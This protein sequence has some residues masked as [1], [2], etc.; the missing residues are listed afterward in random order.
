MDHAGAVLGP[1]VAVAVLT[2]W[3]TDLRTLFWLAAIPGGFAE[4]AIIFGV[5][6]HRSAP[7]SGA[8]LSF[9]L[10]NPERRALLR[11][12]VPLGVFT[13]GNAS[14]LFLLLYA[15]GHDVPLAGLPLL[16]VGLHVVKS[17]VSPLGG[18]LG[19]RIGHVRTVALGWLVYV[20]TYVLFGFVRDPWL[21]AAL[22]MFYG[23]YHGLTE[24]PEKAFVAA[25]VPPTFR[26]TAFGWYHLVVGLLALPASLLFALLWEAYD[27]AT[28]FFAGAGLAG[29]ATVLLWTMAGTFKGSREGRHDGERFHVHRPIVGSHAGE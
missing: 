29:V 24:G 3:T 20:A 13:L 11:L 14:D 8:R 10:P 28:A 6:E 19:D 21:I 4:L 17:L 26:G 15:G 7:R 16:W 9:A 25:A 18:W 12:L 22:F 27:P 5:R 23:L 2:L 1:L